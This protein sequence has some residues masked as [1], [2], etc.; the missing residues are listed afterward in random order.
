MVGESIIVNGIDFPRT[1][2]SATVYNTQSI[3]SFKQDVFGAVGIATFTADAVLERFRF[4]GG[5][6]NVSISAAQGGISTVTCPGKFFN[7]RTGTV[8]RYQK[9]VLLQKLITKF[10]QFLQMVLLSNFLQ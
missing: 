6:T 4:F 5:I 1:I 9:P 2:N 8:V 3:K 7:V 10:Q